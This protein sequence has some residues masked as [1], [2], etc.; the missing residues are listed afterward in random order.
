MWNPLSLGLGFTK[1]AGA[2]TLVM[3]FLV[4]SSALAVWLRDDAIKD[5]NA[6]WE[7]KIAKANNDLVT[8]LAAKQAR[9]T[10]LEVRLAEGE[11]K[12]S[13]EDIKRKEELEKQREQIALSK[14]CDA[15]RI[16]NERIWVRRPAGDQTPNPAKRS[17]AGKGSRLPN[18]GR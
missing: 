17:E 9:I 11:A 5:C 18:A 2:G 4:G 12:A 1:W 15:C 6:A 10:A 3:G 8:Q 14:E 16:P 7:L 13:L